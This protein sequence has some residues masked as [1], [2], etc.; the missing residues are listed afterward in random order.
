MSNVEAKKVTPRASAKTVTT[1]G[2]GFSMWVKL[3]LAVI[4]LFFGI[5]T[6]PLFTRAEEAATTTNDEDTA[7]TPSGTEECTTNPDGT[8]SC[9]YSTLGSSDTLFPCNEDILDQYLHEDAVPGYHVVCFSAAH[10]PEKAAK[11]FL[12]VTYYLEGFRNKTVTQTFPKFKGKFSWKHIKFGLERKL[13]LEMKEWM[14]GFQPWAIFTPLGQRVIDAGVDDPETDDLIL[15]VLLRFQT[16]LVYE[17][18]QFIWPG[19]KENFLRPVN[20]YSI[21]PMGD[22]SNRPDQVVTLRTLSLHPLVIVVEDFLTSEE[23]DYIQKI[24][25]PDMEYSNVVLRDDDHGRPASDFRTSQSTFVRS[26]GDPTLLDIEFRTASLVRVP[27]QHQEDV[28]VLRYGPGEKYDHHHDYFD[29]NAYQNDPDTLEAIDNG[30][31]NRLA[32]V[33]WYL[34]EVEQGGETAFPRYEN[35]VPMT[36]QDCEAGIKVKPEKGRVIIFYSLLPNGKPDPL[37]L[38]GACPVEEGVK[39]AAN[40]WVWNV[41]REFIHKVEY[42]Q[43]EE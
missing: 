18:G 19:V 1:T 41:P 40:K 13:K 39:W 33:L 30:R 2:G 23:C 36:M 35:A 12:Q 10:N 6:P 7:S 21:M 43:K 38:H 37:S 27:R 3:T 24:A 22:L 34:S 28:Q 9:A 26:T 25:E 32:T 5:L 31:H 11:D 16:V 20:L 29:P 8:S 17:G 42:R 14:D 15:D 4:S